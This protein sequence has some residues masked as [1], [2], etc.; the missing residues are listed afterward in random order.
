MKRQRSLTEAVLMS[1]GSTIRSVFTIPL[2]RIYGLIRNKLA[3][4]IVAPEEVQRRQ[5]LVYVK[6]IVINYLSSTSN[7]SDYSVPLFSSRCV[8]PTFKTSTKLALYTRV[9][10]TLNSLFL[11]SKL[12]T[13]DVPCSVTC[14]FS[15]PRPP[16]VFCSCSQE[17]FSVDYS[18]KGYGL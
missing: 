11:H 7:T 6:F 5:P 18:R 9:Y 14:K 10:S 12:L 3:G 16:W 1:F 17:R 13:A 2:L 8:A 4:H 15:V